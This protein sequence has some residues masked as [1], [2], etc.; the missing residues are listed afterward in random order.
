MSTQLVQGYGVTKYMNFM[1]IYVCVSVSIINS[2]AFDVEMLLCIILSCLWCNYS[3]AKAWFTISMLCIE[4]Y[5]SDNVMGVNKINFATAIQLS[6]C[7][8]PV[9]LV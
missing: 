2:I 4:F 6:M 5:A 3:L 1:N 7:R 8:N 9:D